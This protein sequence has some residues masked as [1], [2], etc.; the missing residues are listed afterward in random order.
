MGDSHASTYGV[1]C[2]DIARELDLRLNIISIA[3]GDPLPVCPGST[4]PAKTWN[5]SL[6]QIEEL[7][8]ELTILVMRWETKL[9]ACPERL[10]AAIEELS[11]HTRRIILITQPPVMPREASRAEVRKGARPPFYEPEKHRTQR[12]AK[13]EFVKSH[14]SEQVMIVDLEHL[15]GTSA[16]EVFYWDENGRLLYQDEDHLS[17]YGVQYVKPL[18]KEALRRQILELN[19]E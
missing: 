6:L 18:V 4:Q 17:G 8:P 2:R 11:K 13:N 5:D 9:A 16:G 12:L 19:Q 15:F 7:Q 10:P 3:A 1:M 14:A